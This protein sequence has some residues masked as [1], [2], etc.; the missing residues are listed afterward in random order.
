MSRK[1]SQALIDQ[2]E[3]L[4]RSGSTLTAA[5]REIGCTADVLGLYLRKRGVDTRRGSKIGYTHA[6][7]EVRFANMVRAAYD[8]LLDNPAIGIGE[9]ELA[10]LL[11]AKDFPVIRQARVDG[12]LIDI[13]IENI[14]VEVSADF[15]KATPARH[16]GR[17]KHL[18]DQGFTFIYAVIPSIAAF[19]RHRE[20]FATTIEQAYHNP[21]V[22][23]EYWV[24]RC[25]LYD[26]GTDYESDEWILIKCTPKIPSTK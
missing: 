4:V 20:D 18:V 3:R 19:E 10:E 14:A 22:K 16:P 8:P 6:A 12:Y 24:L 1:L 26:R 5:A 13:A 21:P 17:F 23:G 9:R 15:R 2:A 7:R 25:G 11:E